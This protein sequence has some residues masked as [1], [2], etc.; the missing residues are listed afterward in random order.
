[1][2]P[3]KQRHQHQI[4]DRFLA[5]DLGSDRIAEAAAG[6]FGPGEQLDIAEGVQRRTGFTR[7]IVQEGSTVTQARNTGSSSPKTLRQRVTWKYEGVVFV[8][9]V[10]PPL[11][12]RPDPGLARGIWEAPPWLFVA[13][14]VIAALAIAVVLVRRFRRSKR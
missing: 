9:L 11:V 6:G 12:K 3:R 1:M 7:V 5:D 4:D 13:A 2:A 14:A 10:E 8:A